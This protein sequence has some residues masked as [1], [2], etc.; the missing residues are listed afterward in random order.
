MAL[1]RRKSRDAEL[2]DD[3]LT[4]EADSAAD[5]AVEGTVH[6]EAVAPSRPQGPWD[7]S[8]APDDGVQRIDLGSL[9]VPV[10][11]DTELR[12]EMNA[13]NQVVA[14]TLVRAPATMQLSVFAAPRTEGIWP[15]V[16]AEIAEA[17]G[18]GG[19]QAQEAEGPFGVELRAMVPTEV[20]GRGRVLAPTRF[21]G[22]DGPRWF[23]RAL[24]TGP[25]ATQGP[26]AD[27]LTSALRDVVVVRGGDPMAVRDALPLRLPKD[28]QAQAEAAQAAQAA[29]AARAGRSEGTAPQLPGMPERGPEITEIR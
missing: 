22:V 1:F 2:P 5:P 20:A 23:L 28:V 25:A 7:E 21:V 24:L 27:E 29:Q 11:P 26:A 16:R 17:L 15:E 19:G 8:D 18:S 13:E 10:L 9:R 3:E 12:V 4:T 14:V 6:A